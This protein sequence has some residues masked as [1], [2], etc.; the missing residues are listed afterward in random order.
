MEEFTNMHAAR[1]R[2]YLL[3]RA[4][5]L[6]TCKSVTATTNEMTSETG[7]T[8]LVSGPEP[9]ASEAGATTLV[10]GPEPGARKKE[11]N[12]KIEQ[13]DE[14]AMWAK[15]ASTKEG[16]EIPPEYYRR[17]DNDE[18]ESKDPHYS[19]PTVWSHRIEEISP[20]GDIWFQ[21][22]QILIWTSEW[23]KENTK[24]WN[25]LPI[26]RPHDIQSP[27]EAT[28][29]VI[30]MSVTTASLMH[31]K[32]YMQKDGTTMRAWESGDCP[33]LAVVSF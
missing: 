27:V 15:W 30:P 14:D 21:Q 32:Q 9:G 7:A 22:D 23:Q 6:Q 26:V 31:A 17:R 33:A 5:L 24:R 2:K 3:T 29:F 8:T 16:E 11:V 19:N 4:Q 1:A 12:V 20:T 13:P 25:E 18:E 10:S 28:P